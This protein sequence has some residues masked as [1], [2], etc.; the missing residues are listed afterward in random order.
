MWLVSSRQIRC[1]GSIARIQDSNLLWSLL[2]RDKQ[3]K[4]ALWWRVLLS[5][6]SILQVKNKLF[7]NFQSRL[8][9]FICRR[10]TQNRKAWL[11]KS[12]ETHFSLKKIC[13]PCRYEACLKY[14]QFTISSMYQ[15]FLD[16]YLH[17]ALQARTLPSV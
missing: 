2:S 1:N 5:M 13:S 8:V 16:V 7:I 4:G 9:F 17:L 10:F 11:P 15:T 14:N 6:Q 3:S 12:C